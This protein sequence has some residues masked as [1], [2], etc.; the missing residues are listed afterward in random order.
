MAYYPYY[1]NFNYNP[2]YPTQGPQSQS[3]G[4]V[5]VPNEEE[6]RAYPMQRGSSVT[7][8]DENLPYIYIKT[9]GFGQLDA[10]IFEKYRI[11]KEDAQNVRKAESAPPKE[12]TDKLSNYVTKAEYRAICDDVEQLKETVEMLRKELGA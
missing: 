1:N 9:L 2:N 7:F 3:V 5:P 10:P 11:V 8:R 4:F 6:A 12:E